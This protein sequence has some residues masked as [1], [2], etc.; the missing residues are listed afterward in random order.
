MYGDAE[1]TWGDT[2]CPVC[3]AAPDDKLD[4]DVVTGDAP[5]VDEWIAHN[6]PTCDQCDAEATFVWP[7]ERDK[8]LE[9]L[10]WSCPICNEHLT[11]DGETINVEAY[12]LKRQVAGEKVPA[13]D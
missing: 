2:E 13:D 3:G 11:D 10:R 5:D 1:E 12:L 7:D 4:P 6:R 8:G 9:K